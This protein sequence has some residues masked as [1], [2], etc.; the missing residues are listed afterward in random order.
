MGGSGVLGRR[1][2]VDRPV[3]AAGAGEYTYRVECTDK[4]NPGLN[5]K[6]QTLSVTAYKGTTRC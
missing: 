5:G 4:A 1:Q 3:R 6:E 2:E